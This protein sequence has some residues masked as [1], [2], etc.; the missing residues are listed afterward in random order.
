MDEQQLYGR[1]QS[2]LSTTLL[3]W[4][5]RSDVVAAPI[6][7]IQRCRA[8][9]LSFRPQRASRCHSG[10]RSVSREA[11]A[12]PQGCRARPISVRKIAAP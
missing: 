7:E 8:A 2:A 4:R 5:T 10:D 1:T 9:L 3:L 11:A 12:H 6:V